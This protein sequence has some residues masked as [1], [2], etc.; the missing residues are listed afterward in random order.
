MT[1][2][3]TALYRAALR[4]LPRDFREGYTQELVACF[5]E[6][7]ATAR[8]RSRFAVAGV[9]LHSIL[10]TLVQAVLLRARRNKNSPPLRGDH[11]WQDLRYAARRL[12]RRPSFTFVT[13]LTLALGV[14]AATSVFTLVNGVVLSPLPYPQSD[15]LVQVDHGGR[16]IGVDKG[17]GVTVGFFRFY[18]ENL[19]LVESMGL[20]YFESAT[21]TG[22]GEP[23]QLSTAAVTASLND[24]LQ[25]RPLL[26]RW[27]GPAEGTRGST[28]FVV[29]S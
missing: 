20:Y 5:D 29:I 25:V 7:A 2:L 4:T 15:R 3:A 19:R 26:G 11:M 21:L 12:M 18:R 23:V 28:P 14:A 24:V 16:G 1:R 27:F 13:V 17:L 10:D 8:L 9:L 6:L 22:A